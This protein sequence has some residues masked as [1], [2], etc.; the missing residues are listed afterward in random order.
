M[1]LRYVP[2]SIWKKLY[3]ITKY[4]FVYLF[5]STITFS[6]PLMKISALNVKIAPLSTKE[7]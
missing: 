4:R 1:S 5:K 6:F 7:A 2:F 3:F